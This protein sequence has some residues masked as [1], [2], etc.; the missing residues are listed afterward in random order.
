MSATEY[1]IKYTDRD[2]KDRLD[3]DRLNHLFNMK[4]E[5]DS[6]LVDIELTR[7][8]CSSLD[9][10]VPY[11]VKFHLSLLSQSEIKAGKEKK[12]GC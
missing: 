5:I 11:L 2:E 12:H 3:M 1:F 10:K 4:S 9:T 8:I 7:S 6:L